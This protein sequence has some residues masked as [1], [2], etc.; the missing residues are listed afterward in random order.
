MILSFRAKMTNYGMFINDVTQF[1]TFFPQALVFL[2][3]NHCGFLSFSLKIMTPFMV[4]PFL[5][6]AKTDSCYCIGTI[7]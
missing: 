7:I 6:A 5:N 3:Q 4:Y 2:S 1:L